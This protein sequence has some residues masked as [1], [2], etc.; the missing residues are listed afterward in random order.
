MYPKLVR[1]A[2]PVQECSEQSRGLYEDVCQLLN[3]VLPNISQ[4]RKLHVSLNGRHNQQTNIRRHRI[5]QNLLSTF[6]WQKHTSKFCCSVFCSD[7]LP[8]L[9][10]CPLSD[11]AD[12]HPANTSGISS[13]GN[14]TH[15][16][17][18]PT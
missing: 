7:Q 8:A 3:R 11:D 10:Q 18:L 2:D 13:Q 4:T 5:A 15:I 17:Y 16:L 12:L 9:E 14:V 1:C 6:S